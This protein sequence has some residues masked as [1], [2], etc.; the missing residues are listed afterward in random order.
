[1]SWSD[2][3]T[4][5]DISK[6]VYAFKFYFEI[7]GRRHFFHVY[8]WKDLESFLVNT[9][10]PKDDKAYGLCRCSPIMLDY[11][12]GVETRHFYPKLGEIH[13]VVGEWD[14]EIISHEV[15]HASC[16][17]HGHYRDRLRRIMEG[18]NEVEEE[19]CYIIGKMA[20]E[21]YLKLWAVSPN[22]KWE[23]KQ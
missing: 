9:L 7:E 15:E 12:D 6:V 8:I 14:S 4:K 5:K 16:C 18:E 2:F 11:C 3:N 10:L 22:K 20:R 13:F 21:I 19:H 1:M 17:I 23:K